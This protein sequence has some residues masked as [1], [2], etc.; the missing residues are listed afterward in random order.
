MTINF[1]K[2]SERHWKDADLLEK[3]LRP[4][5]AD[6]LFGLSAECAIK[7]AMATLGAPLKSNG[8]L[9]DQYQL[10]VDQLWDKFQ[11]FAQGPHLSRYAA[12][13]GRSNPFRDWRII[14][15][16]YE[17]GHLQNSNKLPGHRNGAFVARRMLTQVLLDKAPR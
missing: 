7:A 17:D 12:L 3:Q 8:D 13:L 9:S 1:H 2:A 15:R 14:Q 11:H 4:E 10:H 16:Y 5:N 6:H